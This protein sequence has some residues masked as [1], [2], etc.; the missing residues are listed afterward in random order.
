MDP[1]EWLSTLTDH[2]KSRLTGHLFTQCPQGP[3]MLSQKAGFPFFSWLNSISP[4]HIFSVIFLS[5]IV[6]WKILQIRI[7]LYLYISVLRLVAQL[8]PT[9][10]DL[11]DCCPPGSS[12]LGLFPARMLERDTIS[13]SRASFLPRDWIP[14]SY[15]SCIGRQ[16][17]N[18]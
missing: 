13:S 16:I 7:N 6:W 9:L 11:M 2:S 3:S 14:I 17:L 5:G 12:V 10:C 18:H 15:V 8:C 4:L 1:S